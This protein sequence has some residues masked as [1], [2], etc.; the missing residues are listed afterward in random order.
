M[1]GCWF[2][3]RVGLETITNDDNFNLDSKNLQSKKRKA[4][5]NDEREKH[6]NRKEEIMD[7][8]EDIDLK[9][10]RQSKVRINI[11]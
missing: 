1:S 7:T 9:I 2:C 3:S 5:N 8:N 11:F 10:K 4:K 6:Y